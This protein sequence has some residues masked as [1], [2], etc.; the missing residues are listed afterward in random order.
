MAL[1]LAAELK[2]AKVTVNIIHVRAIDVENKGT[3]TTPAEIVSAMQYLFSDEAGKI[4][5]A[6][7]PLF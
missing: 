4:T 7:I 5:G 3:G 2:A 6:R 1:S